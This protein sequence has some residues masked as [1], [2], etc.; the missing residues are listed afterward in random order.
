MAAEAADAGLVLYLPCPPPFF[1]TPLKAAPLLWYNISAMTQEEMKLIGEAFENNRSDAFDVL[2]DPLDSA[3]VRFH[4]QTNLAILVTLVDF[5]RGDIEGVKSPLSDLARNTA[6]SSPT[7]PPDN[8]DPDPIS[9]E[10]MRRLGSLG[11]QSLSELKGYKYDDEDHFLLHIKG[12][13]AD[14]GWMRG[15]THIVALINTMGECHLPFEPLQ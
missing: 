7:S 8:G 13:L 10:V 4:R 2:Y 9:T 3:E 14:S 15:D 5:L 12:R 1:C 6:D 11:L